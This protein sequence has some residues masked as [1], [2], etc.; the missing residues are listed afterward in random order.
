ME[1]NRRYGIQT[2]VY[3]P[4]IDAGA[5]DFESTPVT[6]AAGDTQRS[7]DGAAFANNTNNPAHEGNGIYSLVLTA[8]EMAAQYIVVTVIDQTATKEWEDQAIIISTD[9]GGQIE[10]NQ[11][12]IIGQVNNAAVTPSTTAFEA[13]RLSPNTTD[14]ATADHYN[15]RNILFTSGALLGVMTDITDYALQ[16]TREFFTVTAMVGAPANGDRFV[17]L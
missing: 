17:V 9:M 12:I 10:A 4:L 15:N 2:T 5:V 11:G 8:T 6:F 14:E 3:F 7:L 13:D 1:V 16:N